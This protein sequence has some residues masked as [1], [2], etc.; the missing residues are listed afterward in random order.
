MKNFKF[1][2]A[3]LTGS[4]S[5]INEGEVIVEPEREQQVI[6]NIEIE[7]QLTINRNLS[8]TADKKRLTQLI[9]ID[10]F[11]GD[12]LCYLKLFSPHMRNGI[13]RELLRYPLHSRVVNYFKLIN[14]LSLDI[15]NKDNIIPSTVN[16]VSVCV[17]GDFMHINNVLEINDNNFSSMS[18]RARCMFISALK[19]VDPKTLKDSTLDLGIDKISLNLSEDCIINWQKIKHKYNEGFNIITISEFLNYK[20][21]DCIYVGGWRSYVGFRD[22]PDY[23]Q[24]QTSTT[25]NVFILFEKFAFFAIKKLYKIV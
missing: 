24:S 10:S 21:S 15:D 20:N 19:N 18:K 4:I 7:E 3:E 2:H 13:K 14:D 11:N 5:D 25:Y 6:N 12:G 23:A 16:L 17:Y 8:I 1:K 22:D 9:G